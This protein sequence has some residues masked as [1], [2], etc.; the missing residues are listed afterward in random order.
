[1]NA[2]AAWGPVRVV[3]IGRLDRGDDAIGIVAAER[4]VVSAPHGVWVSHCGGE[5]ASLLDMWE[6]ARA[7]I[8][9]DA[10]QSGAAPGTLLRIDARRDPLPVPSS[11]STHGFGLAEAVEVG[12]ALH[13][14]PPVLIVHGIEAERFTA[15]T[16][17]SPRVARAIEALVACVQREAVEL[18]SANVSLVG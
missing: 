6:G 1:M 11:S 9:I 8:V 13:R 3:G 2:P 18:M 10:L 15:G 17:L 7:V 4:L 12:R 14:L 16:G 5:F